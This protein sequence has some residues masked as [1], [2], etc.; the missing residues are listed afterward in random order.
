M[1]IFLTAPSH[2]LGGLE[3]L[4]A[5][6]ATNTRTESHI[7]NCVASVLSEKVARDKL[8]FTVMSNSFY[9]KFGVKIDENAFSKMIRYGRLYPILRKKKKI[10]ELN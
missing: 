3:L 9:S 1:L 2:I 6:S 10:F 5:S 7:W 8:T 4:L